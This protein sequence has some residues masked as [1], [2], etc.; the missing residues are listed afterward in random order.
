MTELNED[1]LKESLDICETSG[2]FHLVKSVKIF[3]F[4]FSVLED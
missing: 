1:K 4:H 3:L 2:Y